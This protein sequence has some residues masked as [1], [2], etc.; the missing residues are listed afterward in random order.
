[1]ALRWVTLMLLLSQSISTHFRPKMYLSKTHGEGGYV[2]KRKYPTYN[3]LVRK[4][5]AKSNNLTRLPKEGLNIYPSL[6]SN[7]RIYL[8]FKLVFVS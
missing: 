1:M 3:Q 2:F 4:Y 5:G 6:D 7:V 8:I